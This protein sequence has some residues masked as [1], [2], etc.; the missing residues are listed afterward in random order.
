V[1]LAIVGFAFVLLPL[2]MNAIL[3]VPIA[4]L[5]SRPV[6]P[7]TVDAAW[8]GHLAAL[9]GR[10]YLIVLMPMA[11]AFLVGLAGRSQ[12]AGIGAALGLM[13]GE[14][15]VAIL[16][17]SLGLDWARA[18]VDLL[19]AQSDQALLAHN[20]FGPVATEPGALGEGRALLTLTIYGIIC[21][22]AAVAIFRRRDIRGTS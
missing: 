10:T 13:I 2:L 20:A 9:V 17:L 7:V 3:A 14:Q 1:A 21:I 16:L 12:A 5:E 22:V 15:V 8:L 19:P 11:L 6:F 4:M 18:V